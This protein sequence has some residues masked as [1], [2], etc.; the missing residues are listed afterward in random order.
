MLADPNV[1]NDLRMPTILFDISKNEDLTPSIGL[2]SL[3][4]KLR[5]S[6]KIGL[7]KEELSLNKLGDVDCLIFAAPREKFSMNEVRS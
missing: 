5:N 7:H 1:P 6:A 2:K 3:A 4:R